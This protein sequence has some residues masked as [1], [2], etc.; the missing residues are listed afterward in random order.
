MPF[1]WIDGSL[2][3]DTLV[4]ENV[5][6]SESIGLIPT[7]GVDAGTN[8]HRM[9][10]ANVYHKNQLDEPLPLMV[11]KGSIEKLYLH[12]LDAGKDEIFVNEGSIDMLCES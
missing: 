7:V 1:I 8:I 2:D 12:N 11:N 9:Q 6:R 10:V 5:S 3:I 4:I